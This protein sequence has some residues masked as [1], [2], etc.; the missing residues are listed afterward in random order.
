MTPADLARLEK[1][2]ALTESDRDGEAH[3]ALAAT[4]AL[5]AKHNKTMRDI[6][7]LLGPAKAV[8]SSY[9]PSNPWSPQWRPWVQL[10]MPHQ[11]RRLRANL[12]TRNVTGADLGSFFPVVKL[13]GSY[14]GEVWLTEMHPS[15]D[16]IVNGLIADW[17][18]KPDIMIRSMLLSNLVAEL[19]VSPDLKF[20]ADRPLSRY[21]A[22][23]RARYAADQA[24]LESVDNGLEEED[25]QARPEAERMRREARAKQPQPDPQPGLLNVKPFPR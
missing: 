17:V 20:V 8:L 11:R 16:D 5:L 21:E 24:W 12:V 14:H 4:K 18:D 22:E 1:L 10:I 9:E 19:K 23:V 7:T 2:Y 15:N 25:R 13:L 3:A 6:P